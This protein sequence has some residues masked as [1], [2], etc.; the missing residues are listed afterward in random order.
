ME[1]QITPQ[2][3]VAD[4]LARWPE[5]I[6]VFIHHRMACVGCSMAA[7]ETLGDALSIYGLEAEAFFIQ[8]EK[9]IQ[10]CTLRQEEQ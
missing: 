6:P 9:A 4:V 7:F 8:L 5:V 2:L 1:R 10:P 3:M